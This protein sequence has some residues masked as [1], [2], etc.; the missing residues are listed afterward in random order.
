[1]SA[2]VILAKFTISIT[3]YIYSDRY[4]NTHLTM[5]IKQDRVK[6]KKQKNL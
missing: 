4:Q 3:V 1:M 5:V 2:D 6:V